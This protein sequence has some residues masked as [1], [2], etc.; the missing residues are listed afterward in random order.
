MTENVLLSFARSGA[1]W[2]GTRPKLSETA[3]ADIIEHLMTVMLPEEAERLLNMLQRTFADAFDISGAQIELRSEAEERSKRKGEPGRPPVKLGV[4]LRDELQELT[5]ALKGCDLAKDAS[6]LCTRASENDILAKIL[7]VHLEERVGG[8]F[9]DPLSSAPKEASALLPELIG[10]LISAI[11]GAIRPGRSDVATNFLARQFVTLFREVHGKLP[12]RRVSHYGQTGETGPG[13]EV[14][15]I[16]ASELHSALPQNL[17][18]ARPA[19][20]AGPYRKA[21]EAAS[22]K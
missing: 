3:Q 15:R 18:P 13:L 1:G 10:E 17:R 2:A 9:I 11:S 19:E 5:K 22:Q 16:L 8:R 6:A 20:M 12:T 4:K 7:T 14:C 21:L